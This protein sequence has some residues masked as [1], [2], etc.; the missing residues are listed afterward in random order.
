MANS[1]DPFAKRH[2]LV[3]IGG[4]SKFAVLYYSQNR[5]IFSKTLVTRYAHP[6]HKISD[7]LKSCYSI[8]MYPPL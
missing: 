8:W 1:I 7:G 6:N 4:F 2:K 5:L 3:H